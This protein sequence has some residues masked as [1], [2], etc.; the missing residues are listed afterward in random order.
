MKMPLLQCGP[1]SIPV[2]GGVEIVTP[3]IA[4]QIPSLGQPFRVKVH[5]LRST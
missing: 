1:L 3:W 5:R 2:D 4:L